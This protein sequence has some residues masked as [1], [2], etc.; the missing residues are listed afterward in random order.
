MTSF[1]VQI[2]FSLEPRGILEQ[3]TSMASMLLLAVASMEWRSFSKVVW[4]YRKFQK[5]DKESELLSR[6]L[7]AKI[8]VKV[9]LSKY[10]TW[11]DKICINGW[12]ISIRMVEEGAMVE[13]RRCFYANEANDQYSQAFS[14]ESWDLVE[15]NSHDSRSLTYDGIWTPSISNRYGVGISL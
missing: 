14:R 12:I 4:S 11:L 13:E 9:P 5:M 1:N 3:K 2:C 10:I 8:L 15:N 7:Y 6:V